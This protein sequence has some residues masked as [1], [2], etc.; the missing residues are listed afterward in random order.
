MD[1]WTQT[2]PG[3]AQPGHVEPLEVK[4]LEFLAQVAKLCGIDLVFGSKT[5]P[6]GPEDMDDPSW[7]AADF[8]EEIGMREAT[9]GSVPIIT[10]GSIASRLINSQPK[11]FVNLPLDL[12]LCL[13]SNFL[14]P[15]PFG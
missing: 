7:N 15:W 13:G 10:V 8:R 11:F 4:S 5:H 9:P 3:T 6:E 12:C 2:E 14:Q 1:G